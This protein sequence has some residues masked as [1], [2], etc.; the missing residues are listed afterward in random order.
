MIAITPTSADA[1]RFSMLELPPS[2][3]LRV[4][5]DMLNAW[6]LITEKR[7]ALIVEVAG[8]GSACASQRA[9]NASFAIDLTVQISTHSRESASSS[10]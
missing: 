1:P 9:Q 3:R 8:E 4:E 2:D 7:Q 10:K 6:A 5:A